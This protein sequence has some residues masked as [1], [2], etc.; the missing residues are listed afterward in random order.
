[1]KNKLKLK[2]NFNIV[3]KLKKKNFFNRKSNKKQTNESIQN[4][5]EIADSMEQK[6]KKIAI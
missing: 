4:S 6:N 2:E 5:I 1:M 3:E